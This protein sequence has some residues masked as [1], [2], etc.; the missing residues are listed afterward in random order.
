[1]PVRS[2]LLAALLFAAVP[3]AA[4]QPIEAQ[5]SADEFRAAGLHKL[6]ADE[7]ASLN[8]WLGRPIDAETGKAAESARRQVEAS[9]AAASTPSTTA[10]SG[11]RSTP[12]AWSARGATARR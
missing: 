7:L 11:A 5:M 6:S 4:Q 2:I 8:A 10:R 3:V 1:M 12:P 9:R